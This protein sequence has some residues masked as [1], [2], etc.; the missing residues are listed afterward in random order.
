MRYAQ[1]YESTSRD[2][3]I[4]GNPDYR[5][6]QAVEGMSGHD[7]VAK[8]IGRL[9]ECEALG[10]IELVGDELVEAVEKWAKQYKLNEPESKLSEVNI[11]KLIADELLN[12]L[13]HPGYILISEKLRTEA[14]A[15]LVNQINKLEDVQS[16][17]EL[18]DYIEFMEVY[19]DLVHR[20][21]MAREAHLIMRKR[22]N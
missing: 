6:V 5:I 22:D 11:R 1:K 13:K 15:Q 16:I 18:G 12:I 4:K 17:A 3:M 2:P 20:V 7:F 21:D 19:R 14:I 9:D 8:L 10:H